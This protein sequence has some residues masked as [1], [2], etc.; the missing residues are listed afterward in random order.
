MDEVYKH[1]LG[2]LYTPGIKHLCERFACWWL[3]DAIGSYQPFAPAKDEEFQVWK[4]VVHPGHVA[5]LTMDDGNGHEL[6]RQDIEFADLEA[7]EI[8][9]YCVGPGERVLLLPIEY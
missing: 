1:P 4:L 8:E 2:I 3:A 9:L 6:V 5:T 7:C